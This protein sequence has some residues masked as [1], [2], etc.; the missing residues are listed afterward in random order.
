M[1][2]CRETLIV[3]RISHVNDEIRNTNDA[4]RRASER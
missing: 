3:K 2:S 4:F 1:T